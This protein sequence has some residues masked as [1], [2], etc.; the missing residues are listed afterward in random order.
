M[1]FRSD[2][3]ENMTPAERRRIRTRHTIALTA[4]RLF[5]ENGYDETTVEDIATCA[6]ISHRTFF[7]YFSSKDDVLFDDR[8]QLLLQLQALFDQR[9]VEEPLVLAVRASVLGLAAIF[10]EQREVMI[11]RLKLMD[12]TGRNLLVQRQWEETLAAGVAGRMGVCREIDPR[13]D[14]VAAVTVAVLRVALS[15]WARAGGDGDLVADVSQSFDSL[16]T[17]WSHKGDGSSIP[18]EAVSDFFVLGTD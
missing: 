1:V 11:M 13:P 9:P 5:L 4:L 2:Q 6:D 17:V 12:S 14:L 3:M 18:D 8:E 7:R 15:K 10:V 16:G